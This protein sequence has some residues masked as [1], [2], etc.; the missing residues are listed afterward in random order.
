MCMFVFLHDRIIA[1]LTTA[2]GEQPTRNQAVK[3]NNNQYTRSR[4][5]KDK[6]LK[7][8]SKKKKKNGIKQ[9]KNLAN[10]YKKGDRGE[11]N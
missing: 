10:P 4:R 8:E 9:R 11:A 3:N 5:F 2:F 6:K 7:R 1:V